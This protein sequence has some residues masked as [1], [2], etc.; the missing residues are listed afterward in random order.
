MILTEKYTFNFAG[1]V[2][3][4]KINGNL[5]GEFELGLP[6]GRKVSG[7]FDRHRDI[8]DDKGNGKLKVALSDELPNGNKR[9]LSLDT[10]IKDAD[11]K[12]KFFDMSHK[13]YYVGF[14]KKEATLTNTVS[15]FPGAGVTKTSVGVKLDGTLLPNPLTFTYVADQTS[16]DKAD[17][18]VTGKYGTQ[19]DFDVVSNYDVN[20]DHK[21][22]TLTNMK[23][24]VNVPDTKL[25]QLVF[26][27]SCS[28]KEPESEDGL[29]EG[30]HSNTFKVSD[31][32]MALDVSY[33]ANQKTG[34]LKGVLNLPNT[35][36][37]NV[38]FGY[39]RE[40][41]GVDVQKAH[42]DL[43]VLYNKDKK[44]HLVTDSS[45]SPNEI[46]LKA[47]LQSP[48]EKAKDVKLDFNWSLTGGNKYTT[49]IKVDVDQKAYGYNGVVVLS[50]VAPSLLIEFVHPEKTTKLYLS[51]Q[52]LEDSKFVTHVQFVNLL[53][54]NLDL[55]GEAY[56]KSPENFY[57]NVNSDSTKY[58]QVV[59]K[60][61]SKAGGKGVE[62][63][64]TKEGKNLL[65][66]SAEFQVKEERGKTIIEGTGNVKLY[67][68]QQATT[69]KFIRNKFE[70]TKDGE[71][72]V[73]FVFD[74]RI[75]TKN[76]ISE[77]K[78][79]DKNV[80]FK[81]TVCEAKKQCVN[82]D[83]RSTIQKTEF[84]DFKHELLVSV[85]LRELGYSHEFGL[86]ADTSKV[87]MVIDHTVDMH[88]QSQDQNK[89]Q[90]SL[91][92]HK[93]SAGIV[94]T[95]P[96]R[97]IALESVY[98]YPTDQ[99][100]GKYDAGVSFYLD[101][102]NNPSGKTSLT[103]IGSVD[104]TGTNVVKGKSELRLD[105]PS[106]KS[107]SVSGFTLLDADNQRAQAKVT[108]DV[109]Q[110][111]ANK[112]IVQANY[113]NADK[114]GKGFN[115]TSDVKVSSKGLQLDTGFDGHAALNYDSRVFSFGANAVCPTKDFAFG[116]YVFVSEKVFEL[117]GRI[118]NEEVLKV[119][120]N[121]DLEKRSAT[122]N[123]VFKQLGTKP[124]VVTGQVDG[125]TTASFSLS[126]DQLIDVKGQFDLGK[127]ASV[128]VNGNGKTLFNGK[129]ALDD[130]H[131][132]ATNFKVQEEEIKSF[133]QQLQTATKTENEA[134]RQAYAAKFEKLKS[135]VTNQF[136][137]LQTSFPDF[138]KLKEDYKAQ[139]DKFQAE[140]Q[141]DPTIKKLADFLT[142]TITAVTKLLDELTTTFLGYYEKISAIVSDFYKEVE[143]AFNTK[144]LPLFKDL[145]NQI[146]AL[147]YNLYE[148]FVSLVGGVFE[149]IAKA[150]KGFEDD[151]NKISAALADLFKNVSLYFKEYVEQFEKEVRDMWQLLIQQLQ[152]LP[153]LEVV[154]TKIEEVSKNCRSNFRPRFYS[155]RS[156]V[157]EVNQSGGST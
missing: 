19:F 6:T 101:K 92:V 91:Y 98:N 29:Y 43:E 78:L 48:A 74:G 106:I 140:L 117:Y 4:T 110:Q 10:V 125:L 26:E 17:H 99:F 20:R 154:K 86:K 66:G 123:S 7:N 35:D 114:S 108:L 33:K 36:P 79:T 129:V 46:L 147:V 58:K 9:V 88:L 141:A 16:E 89:Y 62:F 156:L 40:G 49:V 44:M 131:F 127:E 5:N 52:K 41:E 65:S 136:K 137:A 120:A 149:R 80:A 113:E 119:A 146:E 70:A 93:N 54:F 157:T 104:R 84:N 71:T 81:H 83:L 23:V 87:G 13:L 153:G 57:L 39:N 24:V 95:L 126:K 72:G 61:N 148:E 144:F 134:A 15:R 50:E 102:A 97:T 139:W 21:K 115:V 128:N 2:E 77:L 59:V 3:G 12:N 47:N 85:D 68:D 8:K 109:F 38:K 111:E 1:K 90:Y 143:E 96:A 155:S 122:F 118:F 76:I 22:P 34:D 63:V 94:L 60:I 67:E 64:G 112:V 145:Y 73:S 152:T 45:F 75:G 107:L 138:T 82:V 150:L 133:L 56:F 51:V 11:F 132:L 142:Q 151:F 42:V 55:N 135:T 14:D 37:I 121:Y 31:K 28:M 53:D 25:K 124:V 100:F 27:H 130:S 116:S 32:S 103:Y 69:F 105:H 18:H 30:K